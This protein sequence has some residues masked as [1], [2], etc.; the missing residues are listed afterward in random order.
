MPR[1]ALIL[2]VLLFPHLSA[3]ANLTLAWDAPGE[4][5]TRGYLIFYGTAP[6]SYTQQVDVGDTTSYTL[7]GLS[8]GTTYYFVVRAYNLAGLISDAS[9][10]V[11]ATVAPSVSPVVTAL[12]LTSDVPTPQAVGTTVTWVATA[13]GGVTPYQ[14]QWSL[15]SAGKWTV[16]GWTNASTWKWTPST[17]GNDYQVRVGVRSMGSTSTLG[18]MVQSVPFT[19]TAPVGSVTLQP[20]VIAPQVVGNTILWSAAVSGGGAVYQYRW[21]LFNGSA[22][23]ATTGWT[24]SSTWSWVPLV[25]NSSYIIGVWVRTAGNVIDAPEASASV[26]FPIKLASATPGGCAGVTCK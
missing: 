18:E 23:S 16:W 15:Y 21:F 7:N 20:N 10:E 12:A 2:I 8:G 5:V 14:Y 22:W 13:T 17:H 6:R 19:V 25:P 11:S 1:F 9:N 3:A 26:P 24:T 4:G